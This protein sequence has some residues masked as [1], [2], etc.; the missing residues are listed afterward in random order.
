MN[1]ARL[2]FFRPHFHHT[3]R[4]RALAVDSGNIVRVRAEVQ[5]TA[6]AA[7]LAGVTGLVPYTGSPQTPGWATGVTKAQT[8]ISNAANEA[9]NLQFTPV[10]AR[11]IM[12]TGC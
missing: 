3:L 10:M 9:D 1:R 8:M 2:L 7:A 11:L 6:D 5:R 12:D 4:V